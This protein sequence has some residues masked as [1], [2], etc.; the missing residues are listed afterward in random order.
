[1]SFRERG[2]GF[3]EADR[4][5]AELKRQLDAGSISTEEFDAQRKQ[6]MVQD[7][8]GRWWARGREDGDWYYRGEAGWAKGTPPDYRQP[9][10]TTSRIARQ[11]AIETGG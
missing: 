9:P 1:M 6:L 5:Y 3:E 2:I 4:R 11:P 7:E 8:K 10:Q